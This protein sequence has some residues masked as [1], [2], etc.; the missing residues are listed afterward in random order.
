MIRLLLVPL[1]V[2]AYNQTY[3]VALFIWYIYIDALF[4]GHFPTLC[5][6]LL[7]KEL[8]TSWSLLTSLLFSIT[9]SLVEPYLTPLNNSRILLFQGL[10]TRQSLHSTPL[11][12]ELIDY[13]V[14]LTPPSLAHDGESPFYNPLPALLSWIF[15]PFLFN[16]TLLFSL[17]VTFL[18]AGLVV[19]LPTARHCFESCNAIC[20]HLFP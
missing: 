2:T 5:S 19:A 16:S 15:K 14:L 9:P 10:H 1:C 12:L 13:L 17:F 4:L 11:S 3:E 18:T 20:S 6:S 7:K 8:Q